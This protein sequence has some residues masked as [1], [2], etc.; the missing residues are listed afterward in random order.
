MADIASINQARS[1]FEAFKLKLGP[2]FSQLEANPFIA[3]W[4]EFEKHLDQMKITD[5][6][7]G[8]KVE[9]K[10]RSTREQERFANQLIEFELEIPSGRQSD[11]TEI[12]FWRVGDPVKLRL[13]LAADSAFVFVDKQGLPLSQTKELNIEY[14]GDWSIYSMIR[15]T[16]VMTYIPRFGQ[17]TKSSVPVMFEFFLQNP[18]VSANERLKGALSAELRFFS[19]KDASPVQFPVGE[20]LSPPTFV[21]LPLPGNPLAQQVNEVDR[22]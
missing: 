9:T 11:E 3:G 14:D 8:V 16:G 15:D 2:K 19:P 6:E 17:L 4:S 7:F 18:E 13:R 5:E 12:A 21:E 10:F 20:F 22:D 1:L